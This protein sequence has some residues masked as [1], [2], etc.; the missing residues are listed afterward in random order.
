M[1]GEKTGLTRSSYEWAT[2][3]ETG[4]RRE[5]QKTRRA[6]GSES[7]G[8]CRVTHAALQKEKPWYDDEKET[9]R[10]RKPQGYLISEGAKKNEEKQQAPAPSQKR[11]KEGWLAGV[12]T[13]R[14]DSQGRREEKRKT[15]TL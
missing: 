1:A 11:L 14:P 10:A 4:S 7:Y 8:S 5:T 12:T 2:T 15:K 9:L 13:P 3:E 6:W